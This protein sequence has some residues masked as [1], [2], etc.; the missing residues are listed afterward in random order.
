MAAIQ[1]STAIQNVVDGKNPNV[2]KDDIDLTQIYIIQMYYKK[3]PEVVLYLTEQTDTFTYQ[4][5]IKTV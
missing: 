5:I 1:I 3:D 4:E 2:T